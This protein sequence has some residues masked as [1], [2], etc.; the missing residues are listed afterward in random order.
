MADT[1][2]SALTALTGA[3]VESSADLMAI[4]DTSLTTTKK[5]T[6]DE[7]R[8]AMGT[9]LGTVQATTSGTAV[10]FT[11]PSWARR[12]TV[13]IAGVSF[14]SADSML[15]QLGDSGGVEATGYNFAVTSLTGGSVNTSTTSFL[16]APSGSSANDTFRG[17]A[18][19]TLVDTS[20]NNWI[21]SSVVSNVRSGAELVHIGAG[22][23]A[24]SGALTT[25]R[26]TGTAQ[27]FDAGSV[28]VLYD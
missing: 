22:A 26:I 19:L 8:V 5:I 27:T 18:V 10:D 6:V 4:V 21:C 20:S 12:I 7:L 28:N 11:I 13:I 3:N 23:K 25:V 2:I 17:N 24:T 1:K 16:I 14:A 9:A 15:L